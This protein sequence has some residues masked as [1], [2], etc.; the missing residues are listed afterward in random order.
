M[1][2]LASLVVVV[3]VASEAWRMQDDA[4]VRSNESAS[5]NWVEA[6]ATARQLVLD[7][8]DNRELT[9]FLNAHQGAK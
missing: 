4:V 3:L 5:G 7:F 8:P 6:V 1:I 9:R 2:S